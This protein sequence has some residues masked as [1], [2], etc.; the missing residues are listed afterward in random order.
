MTAALQD[1]YSGL[2]RRIEERTR[3]LAI[4]NQRLDEASKHKSEFLASVSHELRTPLNAII[5]FTR[6]VLRKTE[7]QIP[8]LQRENLQKV[9]I[10]AQYLLDLI[11]GLLD[12]AKIEAGRMEVVAAPF[13]LTTLINEA[14]TSIE[15]NLKDDRVQLTAQIDHDLPALITDRDKLKEIILN[16]LSNAANFT[17]QGEI[18]ISAA[19]ADGFLKLAIADTGTGIEPEALDCIFD[20]FRQIDIPGGRKHG[21]TGLGLAIVKKLVTLLGGDITVQ[22]QIGRGTTFSVNLPMVWQAKYVSAQ[23][24]N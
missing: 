18:T 11:N 3:E 24:G 12:L 10:S 21:G 6:L 17:E 20:E 22:S 8:T 7:S 14:I 2:E 4:A 19:H 16:L 1:A 15:P 5:G 23:H 9:L 13:Q